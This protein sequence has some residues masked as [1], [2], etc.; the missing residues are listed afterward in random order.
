MPSNEEIRTALCAPGQF[1]E[2]E[3]VETRGVPTGTWK[4]AP[5]DLGA[6]LVQRGTNH[7][8]HAVGAAPLRMST[9]MVGVRA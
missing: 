5:R 9:V 3:T 7:L 2:I 4:N 8:W 1:F 6:V